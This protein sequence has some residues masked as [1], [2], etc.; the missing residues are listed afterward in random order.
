MAAGATASPA[1]AVA[2]AEIRR[3]LR[4]PGGGGRE[5]LTSAAAITEAIRPC[6]PQG[7]FGVRHWPTRSTSAR[8]RIRHGIR[9]TPALAWRRFCPSVAN[10]RLRHMRLGYARVSKADGSQP[11]DLQRDALQAE[12]VDAGQLLERTS[13]RDGRLIGQTFTPIRK[14]TLRD[15]VRLRNG[16]IDLAP[17]GVSVRLRPRL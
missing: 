5:R 16:L 3:R 4:A 8:H 12:S 7:E 11:L 14:D 1:A 10:G 9:H 13:V 17:D 15:F 2:A 6:T